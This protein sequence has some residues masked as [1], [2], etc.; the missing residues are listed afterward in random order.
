M[1]DPGFDYNEHPHRRYNPLT[2]RW[3]LCSPH[4]TKRPWQGGKETVNED[5]PYDPRNN[6]LPG[7][8]RTSGEVNLEYESTFAFTNDFSALLPDTPHGQVGSVENNNLFIAEAVRGE[9]RVL[10]FHPRH[11][12]TIAEMTQEEIQAI[13]TLWTIHYEDLG[14]KPSINYVQIFE[15]KG[16]AMGCSNPHP[17]GQIWS[18]SFIPENSRVSLESQ[19][20]YKKA[21]GILLLQDYVEQEVEKKIRVIAQNEYFVAVIPFWAAWPYEVMIM[22]APGRHYKS[23]SDLDDAAKSGL[24]DA[25]GRVTRRYDNLFECSFPYSMGIHQAPTD[26]KD[27]SFAQMHLLYYPCLLRSATVKK[28]MVGF[29]MLGEPQR[30]LTAEQAADKLN[31]V[32]D[33]EHYRKRLSKEEYEKKYLSNK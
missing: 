24:A 33:T 6:L 16:A 20:N 19:A 29:E 12:L 5:R 21:K 4:R 11:D 18:G 8:V 26:G 22:P 10:C 25:M 31:V 14:S 2:Q 23:L 17:H 13:V 9:C 27:Y 3:L 1:A 32:S 7:A 28:F 15:N 30:D